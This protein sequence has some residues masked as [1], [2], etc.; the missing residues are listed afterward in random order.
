MQRLEAEKDT[1]TALE[2]WKSSGLATDGWSLRVVGEGSLRAQLESW[3]EAERVEGVT[4]V[5]WT[6]D[7]AAELAGAGMLLASA[8]AEPLGLSVIEAMA[9]GVPVV[10]SAG[11]GHL[12]TAGLIEGAPLYRPGDALG[13]AAAMRC[14]LD[15]AARARLSADGRRLVSDR[16]TVKRHVDRLFAEYDA[17][18][19]H[20]HLPDLRLA[21]VCP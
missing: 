20:A 18:R 10:A 9:A 7:V 15:E 11:G 1:I 4:F 16:F 13:A 21:S 14:L 5:G 3:V 19:S 8:P 6:A 17:A 2:A 12:E